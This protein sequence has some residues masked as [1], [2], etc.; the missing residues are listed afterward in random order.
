MSVGHS[1]PLMCK[2]LI[3]PSDQLDPHHLEGRWV[4]VAGSLANN[5]SQNIMRARD[6]LTVDFNTTSYTQ[7]SSLGDRCFRAH[8]NVSMKDH[9]VSFKQ[10]TLSFTANLLHTSC[11]DC[12]L[13]TGEF[14]SPILLFEGLVHVQQE[15]G[16]DAEGDGGVRGSGGVSEHGSGYRD[17]SDHEALPHNARVKICETFWDNYIKAA[18]SLQRT[19]S[20]QGTFELSNMCLVVFAV[21][22]LCSVTV[23]HS[24]PVACEDLVRPLDRQ[25]LRHLEGQ[26]A[27]VAGSLSHLPNLERF[28][29]R[30]SAAV[31][32]SRNHSDSHISY[33]RAIRVENGCMY[34][35]FNISFQG[36]GFTFDGTAQSNL[37]AHFVRTSC[38][39]CT[40]MRMDLPGKMTHMYLFSRRR[41]VGQQEME[42]FRAQVQCLDMPPPVVMDPEKELCPEETSAAQREN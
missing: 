6:S 1:A 34:A 32:F 24:S 18:K 19:H 27:L 36:S 9:I 2:V 15:E 33:T 10:K 31:N 28:K 8:Y 38:G 3:R 13:L 4:L 12:V 5:L 26:W 20:P 37:S 11:P 42:E 17:G 39:D 7:T 21:A 23:S 29:Q 16:G 30:D 14:V 22:L 41:E 40:L 25:D 35:T